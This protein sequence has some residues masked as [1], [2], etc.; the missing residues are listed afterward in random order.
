MD[1]SGLMDAQ[2]ARMSGHRAQGKDQSEIK[3]RTTKQTCWCMAW[4]NALVATIL[5]N[6][7]CTM[8]PGSQ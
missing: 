3:H 7:R 8:C 2:M 5:P 1:E 6:P 4:F